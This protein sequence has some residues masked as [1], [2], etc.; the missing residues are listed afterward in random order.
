ML[1]TED[2]GDIENNVFGGKRQCESLVAA[3]ML[4]LFSLSYI[5]LLRVAQLGT[6]RA[7]KCELRKEFMGYSR[8]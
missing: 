8:V 3:M 7:D 6:K 2:G 1:R 5:A 4:C